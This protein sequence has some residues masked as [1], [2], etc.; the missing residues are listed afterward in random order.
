LTTLAVSVVIPAYNRPEM[1]VRAVRSAL[2]Q[3]PHP[4]AE[5]VVVDDC[6]TDHTG[7]AALAAGARVVRHAVNR[8]E[9]GARNTA[10]REARQPWVA[11]LDSDDEWLPGHLAALW[12]HREGRVILGSTAIAAGGD[13]ASAGLWGRERDTPQL[14]RTPADLL[15][16]GNALVASSVL[17]RRADVI[18]AGGFREDLKL[19]ADLDLWLRVLDRGPGFVSPEVTV[20]YH[21]HDAQVSVDRAAMWTAHRAIVDAYRDRPWCTAAV[22]AQVD[23]ILRWDELRAALRSGDRTAAAR[24]AATLARDP[25]R[26]A[27][28]GRV[29]L[30]RRRL[31]ARSRRY[32]EQHA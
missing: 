32:R 9:G 10:V 15:R 22:R 30:G 8:G 7:A 11:L 2:G 3:H 16:T 31:R 5:V 19:G 4:P 6:S 17:V 18:E 27:S 21:L 14:L 24:A 25:R 1:T 29:V 12:P 26:L 20:R 23:G 28:A 13:P